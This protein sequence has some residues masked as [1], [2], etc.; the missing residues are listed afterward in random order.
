MQ[1][2]FA[3]KLL[4]YSSQTCESSLLSPSAVISALMILHNG[5]GGETRREIEALF[6]AD[7]ESFL[8]Q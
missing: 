5:A 3:I 6:G 7:G 2:D 8:F 1:M 4:R